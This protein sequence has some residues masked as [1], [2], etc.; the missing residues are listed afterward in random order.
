MIVDKLGILNEPFRTEVTIKYVK[1][2]LY[3]VRKL[4]G[5]EGY[6]QVFE[7]L[8]KKHFKNMPP[9]TLQHLIE[10]QVS[11]VSGLLYLAIIENAREIVQIP[12]E[13]FYFI[14]GEESVSQQDPWAMTIARLFPLRRV[15]R[16][17][18]WRTPNFTTLIDLELLKIEREEREDGRYEIATLRRKT[19]PAYFKELTNFFEKDEL[20]YILK[21]DCRLTQGVLFALPGMV[22]G[23]EKR[24]IVEIQCEIDPLKSGGSTPGE[25]IYKLTYSLPS[26]LER[27]SIFIEENPIK[28]YKKGKDELKKLEKQLEEKKRSLIDISTE[29]KLLLSQL[30]ETVDELQDYVDQ[31]VIA[32]DYKKQLERVILS[33]KQLVDKENIVIPMR[34]NFESQ[35]YRIFLMRNAKLLNDISILEYL[36]GLAQKDVDDFANKVTDITYR[37]SVMKEILFNILAEAHLRGKMDDVLAYLISVIERKDPYTFGHSER[38]KNISFIIGKKL[39]LSDNELKVLAF[40]A[41][42]HDVGKLATPSVILKK[43]GKLTEFEFSIIKAHTID[44]YEI[45]RRIQIDDADDLALDAAGHHLRPD[46]K[47]YTKNL[48]EMVH[49]ELTLNQ[50]IISV[51]DAV[52]AMS[53]R[54]VYRNRL[55]P[56]Y[57][58]A[59]LDKNSG[60]QFDP[61]IASIM[62]SMIESPSFFNEIEELR[63]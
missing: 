51:A 38:V 2:A 55:S 49:G 63:V 40:E 18:A 24:D 61:E 48:F 14:I 19:K 11:Y 59:E 21:N 42:A 62:R 10:K 39:G 22:K 9:T 3:F 7:Q 31:E 43:P 29:L 36:I 32:E 6:G 23:Y 12:P 15:L 41:F 53:S 60:T 33:G 27:I 13:D 5:E 16:E 45:L 37:L 50:K 57:I 25:C 54:R 1:N 35:A 17:I 4:S 20:I 52:D 8:A 28:K 56:Q 26:L 46:G 44:T 47:G 58:I 34:Y 30:M